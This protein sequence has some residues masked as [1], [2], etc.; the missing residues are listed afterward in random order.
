MIGM[1][2]LNKKREE[3]KQEGKEVQEI[4]S[5]FDT[6]YRDWCESLKEMIDN[7]LEVVMKKWNIKRIGYDHEVLSQPYLEIIDG[8]VI[9]SELVYFEFKKFE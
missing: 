7:D 8:E 9:K 6:K 2:E 3:L 4:N 1:E 5:Q